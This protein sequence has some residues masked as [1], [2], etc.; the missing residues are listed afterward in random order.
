MKVEFLRKYL[1]DNPFLVLLFAENT[2]KTLNLV[3]I[4]VYPHHFVIQRLSFQFP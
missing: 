1:F 4:L 3:K 2:E